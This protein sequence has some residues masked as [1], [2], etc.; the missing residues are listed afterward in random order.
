MH[1]TIH[2]CRIRNRLLG[3]IDAHGD[4]M[5]LT[6]YLHGKN[7]CVNPVLFPAVPRK[8]SRVRISLMQ[9]HTQED[10]DTLLG[11]IETKSRQLEI[12]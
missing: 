7:I 2:Q 6:K 5:E 12:I 10:L 1:S 9:G 4:W 11:H 8:L 3:E